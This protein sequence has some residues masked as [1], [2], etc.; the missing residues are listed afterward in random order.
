MDHA[1]G[2]LK[3]EENPRVHLQTCQKRGARR[4]GN[5]RRRFRFLERQSKQKGRLDCRGAHAL[6]FDEFDGEHMDFA[7]ALYLAR[8]CLHFYLR[9]FNDIFMSGK[10]PEKYS[11]AL[12]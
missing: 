5:P 1:E 6:A 2:G 7:S 10:A 12:K 9:L 8:F 3:V 11:I 4:R